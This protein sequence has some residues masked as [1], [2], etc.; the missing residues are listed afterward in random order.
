[1]LFPDPET[2][3]F[4]DLFWPA[5]IRIRF[6]Q[7]GSGF[8]GP[9]ESGSDP[10]VS[11]TLIFAIGTLKLSNFQLSWIT[12]CSACCHLCFSDFYSVLFF[13]EPVQWWLVVRMFFSGNM[14]E[15]FNEILGLSGE[16]KRPL[17]TANPTIAD[18]LKE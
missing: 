4:R 2:I 1:M 10:S 18:I 7:V 6:F 9:I 8:A 13:L 12:V 17:F 3:L 15:A 11:V 5:W 16:V 14:Y